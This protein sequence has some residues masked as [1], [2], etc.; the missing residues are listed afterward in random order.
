MNATVDVLAVLDRAIQSAEVRVA[1]ARSLEAIDCSQRAVRDL[2]AARAA[3]A[4][5]I[6]NTKKALNIAESWIHDQLDGT[7]YLNE[8]L[9]E[10]DSVRAVLVRI[11]GAA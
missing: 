11:G 7:S 4:E 3:V 8:S 9:S 5:L 6:K 10:L 2:Y 1:A